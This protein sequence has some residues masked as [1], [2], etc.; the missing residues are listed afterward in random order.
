[1]TP[2]FLEAGMAERFFNILHFKGDGME[3]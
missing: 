1:M 3:L 2:N